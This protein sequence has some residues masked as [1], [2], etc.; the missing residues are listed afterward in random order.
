MIHEIPNIDQHVFI[1]HM[2][3]NP[4]EQP[5]EKYPWIHVNNDKDER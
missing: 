3:D 2:H 4:K 5:I 1:N